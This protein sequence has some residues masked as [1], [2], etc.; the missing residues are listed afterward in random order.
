MS[1]DDHEIIPPKRSVAVAQ[2]GRNVLTR[3]ENTLPQSRSGLRSLTTGFQAELRARSAGRIARAVR[4][5]TDVFN[6]LTDRHK[7]QGRLHRAAEELAETPETIALDK[8]RRK[9]ERAVEYAR[10]AGEYTKIE[11][12]RAEREQ[13]DEQ[14][15]LDLE[16]EKEIRQARREQRIDEARRARL[17]AKYGLEATEKFKAYQFTL[18]EERAQGRIAQAR[19]D[20]AGYQR[21]LEEGDEE[22]PPN[23]DELLIAGL[24]TKKINAL[25][26]ADYE[27]AE[28]CE[29]AL[30]ALGIKDD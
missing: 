14:R 11:S 15:K 17:R 2:G 21:A 7:A 5:E 28:R 23:E 25:K 4:A 29:A 26:I 18:G 30:N 22:K 10:L 9:T 6:A 8:A 3:Y 19:F 24:K 12:E 1:D 16:G 13:A 20:N 27:T